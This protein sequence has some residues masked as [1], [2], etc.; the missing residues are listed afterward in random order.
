MLNCISSKV[1]ECN[2]T[3]RGQIIPLYLLLALFPGSPR[4]CFSELQATESWTGPGN[5]ANLLPRFGTV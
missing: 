5:E 4:V 3:L 2:G 1:P